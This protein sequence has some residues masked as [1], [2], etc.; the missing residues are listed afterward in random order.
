VVVGENKERRKD[1]TARSI[2]ASTSRG[3]EEGRKKRGKGMGMGW[4]EP[5]QGTGEAWRRGVR[6]TDAARS[7]EWMSGC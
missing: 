2:T 7:V 3:G 4:E 6:T 1:T 5:S